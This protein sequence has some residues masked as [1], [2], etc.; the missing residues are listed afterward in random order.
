MR[1][2]LHRFRAG[3]IR[4]PFWALVAVAAVAVA[5][6]TR[7]A[8]A[9]DLGL[10]RAPLAD[11]P[12][13]FGV[14]LWF[15]LIVASWVVAPFLLYDAL[16]PARWRDARWHRHARF[17]V[18]ALVLFVLLF[19][20]TAEVVFWQEFTARFNFIAVDY[21]VYMREVLGN[22]RESYPVPTI[23][24]VIGLV[25]GAAVWRL[26]AAIARADAVPMSWRRRGAKLAAAVLLPAIGWA[27]GDV[28]R[29]YGS[30]NSFVDELSGNG[31][32]TF[33]AAFRRNELDYDRFYPTMPQAEADAILHEL[34]VERVALESDHDWTGLR[35]DAD[36]VLPSWLKRRPR[37]V[38]LISVESLS[39]KYLG[40]Y[41]NKRKRTPN[42]DRIAAGGVV[43]E[44][45]YA[46]G[47]RTVRGLEALSLGTPPV[48]GQAIVRRPKNAHLQTIGG[49][50]EHQGFNARFMYGGYGY[51]DNMNA[52]F[53]DNDYE[54]A[55]RTDF[56]AESIPFENVWG[57]ADEALYANA[58]RALD[59]DA[60]RGAP[61]FIHLMTTS[62]H[63]PYTYP[64]GRIDIPSPGGRKGAVK[65]TDWAIGE[66]LRLAAAKPWFDDT[67][68]VIVA[69][70][71][72]AVAGKVEL[73]IRDYRIPL[74]LWGPKLVV[75]QRI[76]RPVSQLDV[77]PTI[78][79]A[80]GLSGDDFFFG[81]AIGEQGDAPWRAFISNY[82]SLGYYK[83]DRLVVLKPGKR[84]ESY[85]VDPLTYETVPAPLDP[86][87]RDEAI[88]YYQTAARAFSR[89]RLVLPWHRTP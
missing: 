7:L 75:P 43:F 33:A 57:V 22:I 78:L 81:Q 29:M 30:A 45:A 84:V 24:L 56:P 37:N 53:G 67:L 47:T 1:D 3:A 39:A 58:L 65:Y 50:L 69:D 17:A 46:T 20:A 79:D 9:L 55:N 27:A 41:G 32:Y 23:V 51:F 85:R 42:L 35:D 4:I 52:Y 19:S 74:I 36:Q 49:V 11:W 68:F 5:T 16:A 44:R 21:L 34:G 31:L 8:L 82:Q 83:D 61:F 48:P 77:P 72:A 71:C 40:T 87:L 59:V 2:L 80:L 89:G 15:D 38:V 88:A 13:A 6:L 12:R 70:H 60:A 64:D 66:F 28:E 54:V 10:E 76:A 86:R 18:F 73:P 63:R 14:G 26:R 25:A 62:N